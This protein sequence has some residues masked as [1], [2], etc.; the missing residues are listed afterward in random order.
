MLALS[1]TFL[2]HP[3][4][5]STYL[6]P[7]KPYSS[8]RHF[9]G[10]LAGMVFSILALSGFEAP[11]PLAQEARRSSKFIGQAIM[12]S[13]GSI[14]IFYVCTSYASAI[15]WGTGDMAAFA[16]NPN[17]YY[18]LGRAHRLGLEP[19]ILER[20]PFLRSRLLFWLGGA[21]DDAVS[22]SRPPQKDNRIVRPVGRT[23]LEAHAGPSKT[24]AENAVVDQFPIVLAY[25]LCQSAP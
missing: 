18:V 19:G 4:T 7:L 20:V 8:P 6:A 13:L 15:G 11:A 9:G 14:G 16:S 12:L 3:G 17:P 21:P 5:G 2:I 24:E 25:N 1:I 23:T 10:I 22:L